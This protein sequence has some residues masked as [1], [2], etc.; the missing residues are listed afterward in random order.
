MIKTIDKLFRCRRNPEGLEL[1]MEKASEELSYL[2]EYYKTL[3]SEHFEHDIRSEDGP[4]QGV[5][6]FFFSLLQRRL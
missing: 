6:T 1:K 5:W 3:L 2:W 4:Y